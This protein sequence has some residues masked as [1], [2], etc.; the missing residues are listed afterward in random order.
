MSN[1]LTK[2]DEIRLKTAYGEFVGT[3]TQV[4][5]E[6][7]DNYSFKLSINSGST[8]FSHRFWSFEIKS[9]EVLH[10]T[11][12]PDKVT[13]QQWTD[14]AVAVAPGNCKMCFILWLYTPSY[15]FN[16]SHFENR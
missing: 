1:S 4:N 12:S 13:Q 10:R 16:G 5:K 8:S 14:N 3:I 2:D 7:V 11:K 15:F 9:I 6:D